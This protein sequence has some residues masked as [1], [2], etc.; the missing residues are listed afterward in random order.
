MWIEPYTNI[1]MFAALNKQQIHSFEEKRFPFSKIRKNCQ[2]DV[3]NAKVRANI[4]FIT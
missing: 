3:I 2:Y 4:H 1:D